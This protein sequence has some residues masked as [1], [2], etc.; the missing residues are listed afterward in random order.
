[1]TEADQK[2]V[3]FVYVFSWWERGAGSWVAGVY[4]TEQLA[5]EA[6]LGDVPFSAE[7]WMVETWRVN[8]DASDGERVAG[9]RES[10]G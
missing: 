3:R 4:A 2:A 8:Y 10:L 9:R 5:L 1:M 6:A 7:G